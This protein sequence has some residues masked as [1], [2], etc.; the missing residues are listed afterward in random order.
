MTTTSKAILLAKQSARLN[1]YTMVLAAMC[2]MAIVAL[3][4]CDRR[5]YIEIDL[6]DRIDGA[7]LGSVEATDEEEPDRQDQNAPDHQQSE[8]AARHVSCSAGGCAT[9]GSGSS[10]SGSAR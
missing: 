7:E 6:R 10:S 8:P 5:E 1:R 4:G 2:A 3:A 9:A